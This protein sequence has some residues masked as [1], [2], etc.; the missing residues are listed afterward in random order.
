MG[1]QPIRVFRRQKGVAFRLP[2]AS[3][4]IAFSIVGFFVS[5]ADAVVSYV[6]PVY[7]Q[8]ILNDS[9]LMGTIMAS[10]S[11]VGLLAD[12]LIGEWFGNKRY[13]FFLFW[14]LFLGIMFPLSLYFLPPIVPIFILAMGIWGI[15]YEFLVF[16]S[17]HFIHEHQKPADHAHAWGVLTSFKAAAYLLGPLLASSLIISDI[18][19]PFLASASLFLVGLVGL[20]ILKRSIKEKSRHKH[21]SDIKRISVLHELKIW[22]KLLTKIWPV[23]LFVLSIYVVDATFWSIGAVLSENLRQLHPYGGLLLPMYVLPFLFAG[24]LSREAALPYGKKRAAFLAGVFNGVFLVLAG[25]ITNISIL[26]VTV[27]VAS[28]FTA[29]AIPE[30]LAVI[31]DYVARLGIHSNEMVGLGRSAVSLGYVIGPIFAG[32]VAMIFGYQKTL[33]VVGGAIIVVSLIALIATPKKILM[34]Q[35]KLAE[36]S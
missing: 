1:S 5:L 24:F 22:K 12:I 29:I 3:S 25:F 31:E 21:I 8:V 16:S 10:S 7:M 33:S 19:L 11:V 20:F 30:I 27:F 32:G 23:W 18:R 2:V 6:S 15:Y 14:G 17:F 13:N 28:V 26:L 34:P 9:F 35:K 36:E 4:L